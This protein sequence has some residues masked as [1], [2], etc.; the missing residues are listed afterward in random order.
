M[1][2]T[3]DEYLASIQK[4]IT[5]RFNVYN[6]SGTANFKAFLYDEIDKVY[7]TGNYSNLV[8]VIRATADL[9][10]PA[11]EW[12]TG[13]P[14]VSK[15][16][17]WFDRVRGIGNL[18]RD[19]GV[20]STIQN[21]WSQ[22]GGKLWDDWPKNLPTT[23]TTT[24]GT[25]TGTTG[26]TTGTTG[27][28]TGTTGTTTGTTGTTGTT[29]G[30]APTPYSSFLS[31]AYISQ[32]GRLPDPAGLNYY[33]QQ[34]ASGAKTEE[35]I[36]AELNKSL[37]GQN[38]DTQTLTS[39]YRQQFGRDPEQEGYQYWMS[40]VQADPNLTQ[41]VI[42][43]YI[44]G[45]ASGADVQALLNNPEGFRELLTASLQADPWAGRYATQD[46]YGVTDGTPN[47][48]YIGDMG[49]QFV[50][51][52]TMQGGVSVYDPLTGS[53]KYQLGEEAFN[54]IRVQNAIQVARQSGALS[55]QQ[56]QQLYTNVS[57]ATDMNSL[58]A[59]LANPQATVVLDSLYGMQ[60]GEDA[61][62]ILARAEAAQR[63]SVLDQ[64]DYYPSY[65]NFG[66][67]LTQANQQNPFAPG[68]YTAPTMT[69]P[70]D[71]VNDRN[72]QTKLGELMNMS[73]AGPNYMG[74]GVSPGFYSERG[75]EPQFVPFGQPQG[76]TFR[77]GVAGYLPSVPQGFQFGIP[78]VQSQF[79]QFIPGTFDPGIIDEQGNWKP[80]PAQSTNN[81]YAPT[82]VDFNLTPGGAEKE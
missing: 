69:T 62:A 33:T 17:Y 68:N 71:L 28:T 67:A 10:V 16:D 47:V 7:Q 39:Q 19:P 34:L 75:F 81:P 41:A 82:E 59:A 60:V 4:D 42:D 15:T 63:Q 54:P 35:Q 26:T 29:T 46:I 36:I 44:R 22:S 9:G 70:T 50:N 27:T 20:F 38:F 51:P 31:G 74:A 80:T 56:A 58:R 13:I 57:Q 21:L 78:A 3:Y 73:F 23:T 52:V 25:T 18:D 43:E 45:G 12:G 11:K 32:L 64:Y 55:A 79:R 48:S 65:S 40:R 1:A 6:K 49:A 76:P 53:F 72:F 77:S 24:T 5:D 30:V 37:E 61:D 14:G 8:N 2:M 66:T